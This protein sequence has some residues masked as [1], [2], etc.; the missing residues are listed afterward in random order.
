VR[1]CLAVDHD[2]IWRYIHSQ[3]CVCVFIHITGDGM[4][5]KT[6]PMRRKR[7]PQRSNT[8]KDI[9]RLLGMAD[10][11]YSERIGECGIPE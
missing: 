11:A 8:L 10:T 5:G 9:G 7:K 1:L 4:T 3:R 6:A 2:G